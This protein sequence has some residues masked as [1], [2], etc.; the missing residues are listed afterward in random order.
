VDLKDIV[1]QAA[2]GLFVNLNDDQV[3][4]ITQKLIDGDKLGDFISEM[5]SL[6]LKEGD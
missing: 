5:E 1:K 4:E 2:S 3:D 6:I